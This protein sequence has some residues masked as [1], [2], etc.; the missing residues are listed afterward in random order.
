MVPR[1]ENDPPESLE[2]RFR[3][4]V[5]VWQAE[6]GHLSSTEQMAE[7]PAYQQIIALGPAAVPL[8]LRQLETEPDHWYMALEAITGADPV[9][10]ADCGRLLATARA[11]L[12]W[13]REKGYRW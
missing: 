8:L 5:A 2:E 13:G 1:L 6:T 9:G 12:R 11:W 3:R 10:E 4:L 7:H